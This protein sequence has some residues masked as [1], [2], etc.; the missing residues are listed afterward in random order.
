MILILIFYE[1]LKIVD[2]E[3]KRKIKCNCFKTQP[4]TA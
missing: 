2:L 3:K 1:F 4:I